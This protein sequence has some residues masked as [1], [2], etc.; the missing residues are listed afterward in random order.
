MLV[1]CNSKAINTGISIKYCPYLQDN[2]WCGAPIVEIGENYQCKYIIN[3]KG[4]V[5]VFHLEIDVPDEHINENELPLPQNRAKFMCDPIEPEIKVV[6]HTRAKKKM[7]A[8]Q[9]RVYA[10]TVKNKRAAR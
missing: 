7:R 5:D 9:K 8:V 2:N 6:D 1:R 4:Q 10:R 3:D